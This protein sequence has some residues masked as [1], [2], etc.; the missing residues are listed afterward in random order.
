M[1][2]MTQ[3]E[4]YQHLKQ[5]KITYDD[6]LREAQGILN[7]RRKSYPETVKSG[8]MNAQLA[9]YKISCIEAIIEKLKF[10]SKQG[11]LF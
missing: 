5:P 8:R 4:V 2:T 9:R 10:Y 1:P 3:E 11:E 7:Q 6:M